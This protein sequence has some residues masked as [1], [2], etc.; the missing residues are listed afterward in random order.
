MKLIG[1]VVSFIL[2]ALQGNAQD[3]LLYTHSF[4]LPVKLNQPGYDTSVSQPPFQINKFTF[5]VTDSSEVNIV[6]R[7]KSD[8]L[9]IVIDDG[10]V[11]KKREKDQQVYVYSIRHLMSAGT[12]SFFIR[13]GAFCGYTVN[14]SGLLLHE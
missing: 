9:K 1:L 10:T 3:T 2:V 13:T 12:R 11:I 6:I 8:S 14:V 7:S 5:Q 4:K